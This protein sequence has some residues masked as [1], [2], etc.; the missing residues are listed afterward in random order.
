MTRA[1]ACIA[2]IVL[3][4]V[5]SAAPAVAGDPDSPGARVTWLS[6]PVTPSERWA[7]VGALGGVTLPDP[8]LADYQW[9][10]APRAGWGAVT[11]AGHGPWGIGLRAWTTATQQEIG[12]PGAPASTR[13]STT[14]LEL[15]GRLNVTVVHELTLSVTGAAGR[16]RLGYSPEHVTIATGGGPVEV[17]FAPV[18]DWVGGAGLALQRPLGSRWR[19][20]LEME[21][22]VFAIDTAH[23]EGDQIVQGRSTFG[24]WSARIALER[25][26]YW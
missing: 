18:E 6:R 8:A 11:L 5:L 9:Q 14:S 2:L 1:R 25:H 10:I 26:T 15:L 22:R 21:H 13:V 19:A 12:A 17:T 7:S 3:G 23:R 16:F 24:D 20:A 4:A